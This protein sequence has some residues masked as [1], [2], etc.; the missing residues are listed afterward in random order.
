MQP[1]PGLGDP[2]VVE[3]RNGRTVPYPDASW[4]GWKQG[5]RGESR[6]V[7]VNALR[8]GPDGALWVVD[9]G[10]RGIGK[11]AVAGG[12]KL[13]RIDVATDTVTRVYDLAGVTTPISF[14]DDVR[15]HGPKAYL[16]DAGQPNRQV[17]SSRSKGDS[18]SPPFA[19]EL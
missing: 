5:S 18:P 9:R 16:I 15:F 4:N 19:G 10:S 3:V 11:P 1:R 7:G 12:V 13:V 17:P 8:I 14:V 6:F 2:Q